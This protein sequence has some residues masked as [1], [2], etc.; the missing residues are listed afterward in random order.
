MDESSEED[1]ED[2]LSRGSNDHHTLPKSRLRELN[3][4]KQLKR[5]GK[6]KIDRGIHFAYHNLFQNSFP[7]EVIKRLKAWA[8]PNGHEP[9]FTSFTSH[10]FQSFQLLFG[11]PPQEFRDNGHLSKAISVI[12][13]N[14][15]AP[16]EVFDEFVEVVQRQQRKK[17]R[18]KK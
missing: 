15:Y 7:W 10:Q 13:E 6:K 8:K 17:K 11:C 16:R 4:N 2:Q 1:E 12:E 3:R 5:R 14:F 18:R 9:F